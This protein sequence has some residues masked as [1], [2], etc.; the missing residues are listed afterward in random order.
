MKSSLAQH[1]KGK[2]KAT[3]TL[4][5]PRPDV[6]RKRLRECKNRRNALEAIREIVSNLLG[7]EE[8]A[9]LQRNGKHGQ[10]SMIW[11][12]GV[13]PKAFDPRYLLGNSAWSGVIAGN[14]YVNQGPAKAEISIEGRKASALVPIRFNNQTAAV[15]VLL[16]LLPQK[17]KIDELDRELFEVL[18][19]EAGK[20]LFA[21]V[22][23]DSRD[24]KGRDEQALV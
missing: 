3:R 16:R 17:A 21:C 9:L 20:A 19:Q 5:D 6:A 4:R 15:L 7:C 18:S 8:M 24:V 1:R 14:V 22:A 2:S 11:S 10:L 23:S 13:E 12:F